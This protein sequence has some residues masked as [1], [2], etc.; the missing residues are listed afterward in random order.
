MDPASSGIFVIE[1]PP[2]GEPIPVER[3]TVAAF[4]GPAPRG[5][6]DQPVAVRSIGEFLACFGVPGH[7]SRME[8]LLRQYFGSGGNLAVVVRVTRSQRRNRIVMPGPAGPLVLEAL[9]PG[10]LEHLR[11]S[12]DYDGIGAAETDRFNLVVHRCSSAAAPL[13]E[14]Q[15]SYHRVS[16]RAGDTDALA[17]ALAS[18]QLVRLAE[19]VPTERPTRTVG[20]DG[21]QSIGWVL[22]H[23]DWRDSEAHGDYDL[24]GSREQGTG[25]FALD[26]VPTVDLLHLLP[27]SPD[28]ALGPVALFAAERYCRERQ[29]LLVLD[30]PASWRTAEDAIR[31]QRARSF[32]SPDALTYFPAL[33]L[34]AGSAATLPLSAAGVVMG[35]LAAGDAAG[36]PW[37]PAAAPSAVAL[38]SARL[39]ANI[40]EWAARQLHRLGVNTLAR[41]IG[42]RIEFG[43][44]LTLARSGGVAASWNELPRR[45]IALFALGAIARYTRW[46][47]LL[48]A[49]AETWREARVQVNAFLTALHERGAFAGASV[50]QSFYVKCD[51]DTN[52]TPASGSR[53]CCLVVGMA[54]RRPGEFVAFQ[55]VQQARGCEVTELSW[56]PGVALAG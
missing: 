20:D 10:R 1:S 34:N 25:L 17:D 41:G 45:R 9:N 15:E 54:L 48:P 44:Q 42:G 50:G 28:G 36:G 8:L 38:G 37:R 22:C 52:A 51:L 13:V 5:P 3:D 26:Q 21:S 47:A 49:D 7:G 19:P 43:G 27:G 24:I 40:D 14:E 18:S 16:I 53:G 11:A 29:A 35:L 46:T 23:A 31:A 56:Q 2:G 30:P 12:V 6:V 32:S 39:A 55:I 4:V 33:E